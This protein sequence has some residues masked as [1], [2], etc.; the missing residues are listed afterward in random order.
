MVLTAD[1]DRELRAAALVLGKFLGRE[2]PP[3]GVVA[4]I[5]SV[6]NL[7]QRQHKTQESL[8]RTAQ[9]CLDQNAQLGRQVERLLERL[10]VL[11]D[12]SRREPPHPYHL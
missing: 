5:D 6:L 9:L 4:A 1:H 12:V 2:V 8:R 10:R 7:I 11:D 3:C